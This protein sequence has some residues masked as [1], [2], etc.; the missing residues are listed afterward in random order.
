ML[1][2]LGLPHSSNS[3]SFA[4]RSVANI[5][6]VLARSDHTFLASGLFAVCAIRTQSSACWRHSLGSIGMRVVSPLRKEAPA[7][8]DS[9]DRG[10][11]T[12]G[13]IAGFDHHKLTL[14]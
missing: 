4:S 9:F 8:V 13:V 3:P 1:L 6:H 7:K 5:S 10:F 2:S 11:P 14:A 12:K